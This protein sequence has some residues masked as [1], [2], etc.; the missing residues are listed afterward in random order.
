[1]GSCRKDWAH[2]LVGIVARFCFLRKLKDLPDDQVVTSAQSLQEAYL[3]DLEARSVRR[4]VATAFP[5][6]VIAL[7]IYLM[8]QCSDTN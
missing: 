7:R 3:T 8:W 1:M 4:V 5:N 6:I 2:T